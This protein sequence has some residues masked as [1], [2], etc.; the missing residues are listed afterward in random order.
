MTGNG[1]AILIVEDDPNDVLL[2]QR[3][4]KKA[5]VTGPQQVVGDGDK[6]V[7]YL[8]G[9]GPYADRTQYPLPVMV[10]LDLKL[11]RRSGLEVLEWL[12]QQPGLKRLPVV[13]LTASREG[14]DINR[15]YD[16]G[17]NSYLVKPVDLDPLVDMMKHVGV[18]WLA[19]NE[20]PDP[21]EVSP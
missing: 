1:H 8:A 15:A 11:P 20:K 6:A 19:L 12:R 14:K 13:M 5:N 2:I 18:Y 17:A 3:A 21:E 16:L 7:A 9:H 4:L 10:L